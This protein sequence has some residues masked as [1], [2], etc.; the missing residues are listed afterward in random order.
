MKKATKEI[1][2]I[3][4]KFSDR[5]YH[6]RHKKSALKIL[7]SIESVKGKTDTKLIKLSDEYATEILGWKGYAPWLYVY[8]AMSQVF[9]EGWIP[10][11]YYGRIVTPILK[12]NYGTIGDYNSLTS[13]LFKSSHFPDCVYYTNGLWISNEYQILS[14]K[15]VIAFT[16]KENKNLVYKTDN[17]IQG[18]GVHF[19]E[20]N[21]LN[22][23]K[24]EILGNG[25]LQRYINQ[26]S[27]FQD[28][29]PNS[30]AT[31]RITSVINDTGIVTVNAC[32]LRVGR[33]LDTHVKSNSHIRIPINISTGV[34]DKY[35]YTTNWLQ[36]EK[37]LD[38]NFLFESKQI[39]C[40][41]KIIDTAIN[42]HKMVP[43]TRTIGWDMIV[44]ENNDVKVMEW[45]GGHNDIKFSEATQGPCFS[46]LGWEKLWKKVD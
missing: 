45:N 8:S 10:D 7:K 24:L 22:I 11:N 5:S 33:S 3:K 6:S 46:N 2:K 37:H 27:F 15:E 1:K 42:L 19:L 43:F 14:D 40:F 35:G 39:P 31:L 34:L 32:Y 23:K 30:V 41:N 12:G 36:I 29:T 25:V 13:R 9:K 4:K 28:I 18:K 26:H 16:L 38:T 21:N 17:S 20:K 44:D